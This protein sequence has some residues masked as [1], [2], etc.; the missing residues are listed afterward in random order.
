MAKTK[1]D[2]K[3]HAKKTVATNAV[4]KEAGKDGLC[5]EK[6]RHVKDAIEKPIKALRSNKLYKPK[7]IAEHIPDHS[8]AA[9]FTG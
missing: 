3:A 5:K 2:V 6:S 1:F 7:P 8:L 9:E 4:F